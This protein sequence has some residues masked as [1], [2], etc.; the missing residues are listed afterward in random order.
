MNIKKRNNCKKADTGGR[1][2]KG[3][4]K[5]YHVIPLQLGDI[6]INSLES[7][8]KNTVTF[9]NTVCIHHIF[10]GVFIFA[11]FASPVLFANLTIRENIYLRSRSM[12]ATC[13]HNTL[14]VQYTVHVQGR[15]ANFAFWKW[16]NDKYWFLRPF[17][18][19]LDREFNHLRK[20]LEAPIR[21]KWDLQNIWRIQYLKMSGPICQYV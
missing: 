8:I 17:A 14:V 7:T 4:Y 19:L 18:L 3:M 9:C 20:C 2:F 13:V 10:R 5:N 11:N 16:V 15:I 12:N 21:E 1:I 6:L